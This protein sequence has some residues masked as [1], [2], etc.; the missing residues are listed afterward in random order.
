MELKCIYLSWFLGRGIEQNDD[1]KLWDVTTKRVLERGDNHQTIAADS[2]E[3]GKLIAIMKGFVNR[4]EPV[5]TNNEPDS[6]F[7]DVIKLESV[8][9]DSSRKNLEVII[10]HLHEKYPEI[11]PTLPTK[12]EM[13]AAFEKALKYKPAVKSK[14]TQQYSQTQKKEKKKRLGIL[15]SRLRHQNPSIASVHL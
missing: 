11:V 13:D 1:E 5:D 15:Q 14:G 2:I 3:R 10:N 9:T 4:F 12:E 6:L 7:D 8:G